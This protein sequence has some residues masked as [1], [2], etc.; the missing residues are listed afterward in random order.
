MK[1]KNFIIQFLPILLI[2]IL[3]YVAVLMEKNS[4]LT[5]F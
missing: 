2:T 1:I 4:A 3:F 5:Y